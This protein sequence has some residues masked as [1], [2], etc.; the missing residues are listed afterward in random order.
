MISTEIAIRSTREENDLDAIERAK[1]E[2]DVLVDWAKKP[3]YSM[4]EE[5]E[6]NTIFWITL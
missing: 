4:D 6:R 3:R 2:W 1:K 5:V